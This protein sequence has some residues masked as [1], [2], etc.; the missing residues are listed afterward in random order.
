MK[1]AIWEPGAQAKDGDRDLLEVHDVQ[2]RDPEPSEVLVRTTT[3]GVCHSDLHF[4][5]GKWGAA[6]GGR[7]HHPRPRGRRRRRRS[8]R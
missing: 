1:A 4:I 3:S 6:F 7:T 8:W 2:V 5:D